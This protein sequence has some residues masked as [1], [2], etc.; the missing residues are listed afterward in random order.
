MT[1]N[2]LKFKGPKRGTGTEISMGISGT[3]LFLDKKLI[4]GHQIFSL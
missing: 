1:N 4:L 2:A 3:T